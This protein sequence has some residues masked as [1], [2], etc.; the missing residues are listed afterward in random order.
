MFS[1]FYLRL[2]TSTSSVCS[3]ELHIL[4]FYLSSDSQRLPQ[5][6][7][8]NFNL[9]TSFWI[10]K[11]DHRVEV[12][13]PVEIEARALVWISEQLRSITI[14]GWRSRK[15]SVF[16]KSFACS[17]HQI[18]FEAVL[19]RLIDL[20]TQW[21]ISDFN[22]YLWVSIMFPNV[23]HARVWWPKQILTRTPRKLLMRN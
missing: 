16:K 21:L 13:Q 22:A 17:L 15:E 14:Q 7:Q 2:R 8:M 20:N 6:H 23:F 19:N 10:T 9:L 11:H 3:I 1:S 5:W 18:L 12:V 4:S